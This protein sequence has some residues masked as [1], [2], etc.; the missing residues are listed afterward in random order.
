MLPKTRSRSARRRWSLFGQRGNRRVRTA[1]PPALPRAPRPPLWTTAWGAL[2]AWRRS[3]LVAA[4]G[5]TLAAS[6]WAGRWYVTH[7]RHFALHD[8]RV[9]AT[10]HVSAEALVAR[11]NVPLGVN[12]FAIDRDEVARAVS[13]E[14]WVARAHVRRELP[15]TLMIDVVEREP[16]CAVAFGALYLAD[17]DGN[18]FKRGTPEEAASLPVVTGIGRDEYVAQPEHARD[19]LRAALRAIAAWRARGD[20]PA[21]GEV[22]IDRIGGVTL[23]TDRGIGVRLGA[24]DDTLPARLARYDAVTSALQEG[25]EEARLVYVDNRARPDRVTVKLASAQLSAHSGPKE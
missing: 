2:V 20:R 17:G 6:A 21:L 14:P 9:S 22:H 25:G 4:V 24:V 23:Y 12:L 8:V 18:V 15:S 13:Q 19:E 11:A 3:L 16:A 1:T 7:A 10:A 5:V